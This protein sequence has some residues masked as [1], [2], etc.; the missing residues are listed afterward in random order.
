MEKFLQL[1]IYGLQLGSIYA[2]LAI[3]YTM[4]FGIIRM[5]NMAHGDFLMMGSYVIFFIVSIFFA[6]QM[7]GPAVALIVMMVAAVIT[8]GIG[9][10]VERLAYK[11]LRN[12]PKISSMIAAIGVSL[13]TQ[14][15]LRALP[16]VGPN[17]RTFPTLMEDK[18]YYIGNVQLSLM[19]IIII[20]LSVVV[21]LVL[22]FV[23]MR[24][25]IGLQMR[26]VSCDKDASSLMGVNINSVIS[27]TF[28]IGAGLAA[29]SG[30]FYATSYPIL[31]V[32]MGST[33][34]NKAFI[35]AVVGGIGDI[36]GAM[37]GGFIMGVIEILI[38]SV[39][40][41]LAYGFSFVVLVLIL[42][43]KPEGLLGKPMIE[44]V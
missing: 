43:I 8:G 32:T 31:M 7:I 14:N 27:A 13:F 15:L 9:V 25:K 24:T 3:G 42:L 23:V 40:S 26:A 37:L 38:S 18:L 5:I 20:V 11:P 39:Y 4:V 34:G 19:R 41:E 10:G 44:K 30:A 12:R 35:A 21:M 2:L 36:R 16:F 29:I 1:L 22:Y 28:F 33:L 6:D 17:P